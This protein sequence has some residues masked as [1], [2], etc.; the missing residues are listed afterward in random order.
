M[1]VVT[2]SRSLHGSNQP[3]TACVNQ[4]I[5]ARVAVKQGKAGYSRKNLY[6]TSEMSALI[7][8]SGNKFTGI[9]QIQTRESDL[10]S[11]KKP[12]RRQRICI[13]RVGRA[14]CRVIDNGEIEATRS[15]ALVELI[16]DSSVVKPAE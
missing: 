12:V 11:V 3:S 16:S 5:P 8:E 10:V 15:R 7:D 6:R 1:L 14:P 4:K 13:A 2:L 9:T